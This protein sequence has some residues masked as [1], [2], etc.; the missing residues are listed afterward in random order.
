MKTSA[1]HATQPVIIVYTL[2]S[3]FDLCCAIPRV[4]VVVFVIG[5]D[6]LTDL[7]SVQ[8]VLIYVAPG[9]A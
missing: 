3:W 6:Y 2:D 1:N 4:V 5:R 9:V 7:V 8:R